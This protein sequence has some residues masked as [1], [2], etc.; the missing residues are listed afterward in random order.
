MNTYTTELKSY[1]ASRHDHK[2]QP[3][4]NYGHVLEEVFGGL[5]KTAKK[6]T[7]YRDRRK[8]KGKGGGGSR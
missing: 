2:P 3:R 8:K 7:V 5:G 4:D 1:L 6:V